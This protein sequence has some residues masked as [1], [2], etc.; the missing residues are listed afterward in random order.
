MREMRTLD[1]FNNNPG[2]PKGEL[3][4]LDGDALEQLESRLSID[5]QYV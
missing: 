2:E 4:L 3:K 1:A 5:D